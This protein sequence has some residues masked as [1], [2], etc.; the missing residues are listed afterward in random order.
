MVLTGVARPLAQAMDV[1]DFD[2]SVCGNLFCSLQDQGKSQKLLEGHKFGAMVVL[3]LSL[4]ISK[5]TF[6]YRMLWLQYRPCLALGKWTHGQI[7]CP[8]CWVPGS[9]LLGFG[10]SWRL[11]DGHAVFKQN[12]HWQVPALVLGTL[13]A[14]WIHVTLFRLDW[15]CEHSP[16]CVSD[17]QGGFKLLC[18]EMSPTLTTASAQAVG[19]QAS[20]SCLLCPP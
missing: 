11:D 10:C 14:A 16:G 8:H 6:V 19:L 13:D 1:L 15:A 12:P 17:L 7:S 18:P 9:S 4:Q 2:S 3:S 5:A 20:L